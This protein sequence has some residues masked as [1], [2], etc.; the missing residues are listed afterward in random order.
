MKKVAEVV[1]MDSETM[2]ELQGNT[3][4]ISQDEERIKVG[5]GGC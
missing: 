2:A 1:R 5:E 4:M 3:C